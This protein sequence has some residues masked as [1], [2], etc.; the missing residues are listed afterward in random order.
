MLDHQQKPADSFHSC[1]GW[2][3]GSTGVSELGQFEAVNQ[4]IIQSCDKEIHSRSR[5][6]E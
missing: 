2:L 5:M 4:I 1:S 3:Q 6:C